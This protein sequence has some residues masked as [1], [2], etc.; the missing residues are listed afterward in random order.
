MT[1]ALRPSCELMIHLLNNPTPL[2]PWHV[3]ERDDY[4]QLQTTYHA[5]Y[6]INPIYDVRIQLNG[7]KAE[8]ARL[9]LQNVELQVSGDPPEI[10]VP[11]VDVHEVVLVELG[12]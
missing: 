9:P 2:L 11:Q 8:S 4:D 12:P 3:D 6:E 10:I 1:A 7:Y 5:L